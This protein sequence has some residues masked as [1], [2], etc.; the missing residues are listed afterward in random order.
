MKHLDPKD[1]FI[2]TGTSRKYFPKSHVRVQSSAPAAGA[3]GNNT[4]LSVFNTQIRERSRQH[5]SEVSNRVNFF[6][7]CV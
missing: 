7:D 2:N 4:L 5:I 3:S 1:Q 6:K